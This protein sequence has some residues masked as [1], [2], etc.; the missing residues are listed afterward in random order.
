[1]ILTGK[2]EYLEKDLPQCY[3]STTNPTWTVLGL[4]P[5]LSRGREVQQLTT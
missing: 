5:G 1:M 4:N 3:F 2:G